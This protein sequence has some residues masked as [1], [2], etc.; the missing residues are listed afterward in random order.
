MPFNN[1]FNEFYVSYLYISIGK[2]LVL[3]IAIIINVPTQQVMAEVHLQNAQAKTAQS[4]RFRPITF[5]ES[6][7]DKDVVHDRFSSSFPM[8]SPSLPPPTTNPNSL[9]Q[10]ADQKFPAPN[11]YAELQ[12]PTRVAIAATSSSDVPPSQYADEELDYVRDFSWNMFQVLNQ[13]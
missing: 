12:R 4:D 7:E 5:P 10:A 9:L 2:K 11:P 8:P 1:K 13:F 6:E 3:L